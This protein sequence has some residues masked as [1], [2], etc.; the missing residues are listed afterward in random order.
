VELLIDSFIHIDCPIINL[1]TLMV[2]YRKRASS[3]HVFIAS[4]IED[5]KTIPAGQYDMLCCGDII[6]SSFK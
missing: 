5:S 4:S 1:R 3:C 2:H 6:I